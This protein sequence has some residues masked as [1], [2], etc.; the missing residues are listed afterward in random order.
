MTGVVTLVRPDGPQHS[1]KSCPN[2]WSHIP[3][4]IGIIVTAYFLHGIKLEINGIKGTLDKHSENFLEI[5]QDFLEINQKVDRLTTMTEGSLSGHARRLLNSSVKVIVSPSKDGNDQGC[6]TLAYSTTLKQAVVVTNL[7]VV[8][9]IEK[10]SACR[11]EVNVSTWSGEPVKVSKWLALTNG[12]DV[13]LGLTDNELNL[14]LLDISSE[15]DV[16][17]GMRLS[18]LSLRNSQVSLSAQ[19]VKV[20]GYNITTDAGG[21][22][23]YSGTGFVDYQG[24][25]SVIHRGKA[26]ATEL[27]GEGNEGY[28]DGSNQD[29][30]GFCEMCKVKGEC[31]RGLRL[32]S[33]GYGG[34]IEACLALVGQAGS[35]S[36]R[37]RNEQICRRGWNMRQTGAIEP[38]IGY[39]EKCVDYFAKRTGNRSACEQGWAAALA[40]SGSNAAFVK[41]CVNL[42]GGGA[43]SSLEKCRAG[44]VKDHAG[45][46]DACASYVELSARNPRADA[47]GAWVVNALKFRDLVE[48]V[49]DQCAVGPVAARPAAG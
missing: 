24:R 36:D 43:P 17:G 39:V 37:G 40:S 8:A 47:L 16:D 21:A 15:A 14:P 12:L 48:L 41:H 44:W 9:A 25:L 32:G 26:D 4:V 3:N 29:E 28:C 2:M 5:N 20:S 42:R 19:V 10:N 7:H 46:A 23:G 22:R 11:R 27:S 1:L 38:T 31:S 18:A 13:A 6:G 34:H 49:P 33:T 35:K 45:L 30:V